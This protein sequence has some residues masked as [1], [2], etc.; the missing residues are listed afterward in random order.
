MVC[1]SRSV[2]CFIALF[3]SLF[4]Q[5]CSG[6]ASKAVPSGGILK[7]TKGEP[8]V[9]ALIVLHPLEKAR[10]N[11]PKPVATAD[12]NGNFVLRTHTQDDG[13]EPGEYG[14][15]VVWLGATAGAKEFSLSSESGGGATDRLSGRY[16]NPKDPKIKI[17]IPS[18]GDKS[19]ALQV[20]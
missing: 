10:V 6:K 3:C 7:T 1:I 2:F 20:E 15:T 4:L 11:D 5:G 17:T 12:A 13:A 9:G 14:V 16:G 8:C 19:I 18:G